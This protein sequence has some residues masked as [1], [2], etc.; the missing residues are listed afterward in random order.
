MM[1]SIANISIFIASFTSLFLGTLMLSQ[2]EKNEKEVFL[3]LFTYAISGWGVS[4]AIMT[5]NPSVWW[6]RFAFWFIS[7]AFILFN[8]FIR[9]YFFEQNIKQSNFII[10][11]SWVGLFFWSISFT[12]LIIISVGITELSNYYTGVTLELG[13]LYNFL[14]I[15]YLFNFTYIILTMIRGYVLVNEK[16]KEQLRI[17]FLGIISFT[18]LGLVTNLILPRLGIFSY[19]NLGPVFSLIMISLMSYVILRHRLLNVKVVAT[20]IF[21]FVLWLFLLI[22]LI[23]SRNYQDVILNTVVLIASILIGILLIRSVYKEII[24]RERSEKLAEDLERANEEQGNLIYFITHQVKGFLTKTRNIFSLMLE[25]DYGP[26]PPEMLPAIK[27]GFASDSRGA[28]MVQQVL[29]A[30][31]IKKGTMTY[32]MVEFDFKNLVQKIYSELEQTGKE[33]GLDMRLDIQGENFVVNGDELQLKQVVKNLIDNA[34]RYT[35]KG[36]VHILLKKQDNSIVFSVADTG[37]GMT[38]DDK[39]RLFTAGGRGK[40]SRKTNVDSTGFGLFI[41]KRIV[42]AHKGTVT[43]DSA[44]SGKGSVFRVVL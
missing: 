34:I 37:V 26:V 15:Y 17:F 5:L 4:I 16:I 12:D 28:S 1:L 40:D 14:L 42:E 29:D 43:A 41:V 30:S 25:G 3:A 13:K 10:A 35:L 31:N 18:L 24:L 22:K 32:T 21:I 39:T 19:N 7:L 36:S 33:K 11:L 27:E 44:G 38:D 23:L 9:S 20:Q 8:L 6:P 2:H